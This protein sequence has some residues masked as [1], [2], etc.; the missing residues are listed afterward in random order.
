MLQ[1]YNRWKVLK[2][3]FETPSPEGG[4]QLREISRKIKLAPTSVKIYLEGL[5]KERL[6]IKAKHRVHGYPIYYG[7]TESEKFKL[8]KKI[9]TV[10]LLEESGLIKYLYDQC[11]PDAII[12]FGSASKGEDTAKSDIDIFLLCKEKRLD[13]DKYKKSLKKEINLFFA[14]N[15]SKLSPEFGNNIINGIVLKGYLKV[16]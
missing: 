4:F 12:L 2:I 8:L 3:F 16:F 14:E 6:V 15:F 5:S 9:N 7:N 10:T 1:N 11:T 13:L